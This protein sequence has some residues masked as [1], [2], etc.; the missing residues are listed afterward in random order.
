[1][2]GGGKGAL[3]GT[4]QTGVSTTTQAP[5]PFMMPYIGTAYGQAANLLQG[6]G[7]QYYPGQTVAGFNPM[8]DQAFSGIQSLAGS[9]PFAAATRFNNGLLKGKFS[10][11]EAE[12]QQMGEGGASNPYLDSMFQQAAGASQN[13]LSSEFAGAGR[14]M[15]AAAP[16]RGEQ[17]N[18]LATSM[19]G[20]AY[21]QDRANALAANQ[22]LAG[23]QQG[24]VGNAQNLVGGRLGLSNALGSAGQQIQ[25]Q[26]Q[27][28]LDAS[29]AAYDYNQNLPYQNLEMF[30]HALSAL[31]PGS[32]S[33]SPY[34][35]N[36]TGNMLNTALMAQQLYN[37]FGGKGGSSLAPTTYDDPPF[38]DSFAQPMTGTGWDGGSTLPS[39]S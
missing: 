20:G 12:L 17:L 36:P 6:G 28:M 27:K 26:S 34:Y 24:A 25:N 4:Q 8:Q 38:P 14:S 31:Q 13:Q 32:Q 11:P 37:V 16:L 7:P 9:K 21:A 15:G 10:G 5:P 19:Y 22:A 33:T 39:L 35:S 1:M 29:K 2:S 18:N 30:E 23:L 3:G